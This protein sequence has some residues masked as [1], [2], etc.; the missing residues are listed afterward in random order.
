MRRRPWLKTMLVLRRLLPIDST[1]TT[2]PSDANV[3]GTVDLTGETENEKIA[4]RNAKSSIELQRE[5][6]KSLLEKYLAE[7]N[8]VHQ[9]R[10]FVKDFNEAKLKDIQNCILLHFPELTTESKR[11][12]GATKRSS[13]SKILKANA[14]PLLREVGG[15]SAEKYGE[16]VMQEDKVHEQVIATSDMQ[17]LH[18]QW[19]SGLFSSE[20]DVWKA[21]ENAIAIE[22][23]C[24]PQLKSHIRQYVKENALLSSEPTRKGWIM[25][26]E[27]DT[28]HDCVPIQYIEPRKLATFKSVERLP[29]DMNVVPH[30]VTRLCGYEAYLLLNRAVK[31][32]L[33]SKKVFLEKEDEESLFLHLAGFIVSDAFANDES[34]EN[35][36]VDAWQKDGIQIDDLVN[37]TRVQALKSPSLSLSN[38]LWMSCNVK[39]R[40]LPSN[41]SQKNLPY[42]L[43]RNL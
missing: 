24:E 13:Y 4:E 34:A 33:V 41:T 40:N 2:V 27:T 10:D 29:S 30:D 12:R 18:E 6:S 19:G 15:L 39:L 37:R 9:D 25:F 3:G 14:L 36:L 23:Q 16:N 31:E 42:P 1:S 38:W 20:K 7:L 43:V 26:N 32:G 35:Q 5:E 8:I 21:I 11:K 28:G 22:L 17:K